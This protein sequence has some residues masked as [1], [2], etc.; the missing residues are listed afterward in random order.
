[1]IFNSNIFLIHNFQLKLDFKN[2]KNPNIYKLVK[3]LMLK[4]KI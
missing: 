3:S 4:I 1:M 2:L